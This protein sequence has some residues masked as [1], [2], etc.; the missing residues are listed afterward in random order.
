VLERSQLQGAS[1]VVAQL[2]GASLSN[3][4]LQGASL[5]HAQLQAAVFGN[6]ELQGASL[7][8]AQLQGASIL[9]AELQGASL[10][11]AFVWRTRP[12]LKIYLESAW[13]VGPE[14][15]PKYSGLDCASGKTCDWSDQAYAALKTL[16][17]A[18]PARSVLRGFGGSTLDWIKQLGEKPY[19]EDI[20]AKVWRDLAAESQLSAKAYP[21]ELAKRLIGIGCAANGAPYVIGGLT[22]QLDDRFRGNPAQKAEVAR[23]FLDEAN[24]PGAQGL[25]EE[26]KTKLQQMRSPDRPQPNL[27]DASR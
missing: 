27:G 13:I 24:C 15:K 9:E 19:E 11:D 17:E 7:N 22:E 25:S 3:A 1:L 14:P 21:G 16:I 12:P 23:A 18:R 6:A 5:E 4:H 26:K 10:R 20:F 8:Y 2:Q